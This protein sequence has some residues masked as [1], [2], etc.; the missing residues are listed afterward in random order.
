MAELCA[1]VVVAQ[2]RV[3]VEV[4]DVQVRVPPRE[5]AHRAERHQ[6]LPAQQQG[7]LPIPQDL[8]RPRLDV[9]KGHFRA[10]KAELQV[11]AVKD[12]AVAKVPVLVGAVRLQA[13]ALVRMG[14]GAEARARPE[15]GRG[16]KRRARRAR[17]TRAR[18]RCRQP[19]NVLDVRAHHSSTLLEHLLQERGQVEGADVQARRVIARVQVQLAPGL[20]VQ[21]VR[22]GDTSCW[23]SQRASSRRHRW[24]VR[25]VDP[26]DGEGL[27]DVL[28]L[29]C[30]ALASSA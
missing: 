29:R 16:V 11:P 13:E 1:Q 25:L 6:V 23:Q 30:M 4:D 3:G 20:G 27:D 18:S 14:R 19:R 22:W 26:A 12:R 8:L 10:A 5:R 21:V 24:D 2:V 17:R 28:V 9:R 15:A 7:E